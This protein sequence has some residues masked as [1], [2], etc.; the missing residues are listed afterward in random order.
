MKTTAV[1]YCDNQ[2]GKI[3][4]KVA[5]G[6]VRHSEKHEIVGI[7]DSSKVGL[8]AG[9]YLDGIKNGIPIFHDL[10]AAIESLTELPVCFIYGVAPL[11]AFLN[12][13]QRKI[14][15]R[16]I[17]KGMDIV[18]G[19]H[20][21]LTE[22]EEFIQ[23]AKKYGVAINDIRKPPAKKDLHLFS[24]R[25]L[26]IKIPIV[27]VLG[28]DGAVGK[29][30]T[31]IRLVK[32]L[33]KVGLNVAFVSTGQTGLIQGSKYGIAIDAIVEEFMTG[34]M[35]NAVVEAYENEH[36]DIII[37][38]GQGALSHPAYL[39][40][41]AIIRGARPNAI[42]VQH[43][44]KRKTICDFPYMAMPTLESEIELLEVFSKVKV[45]AL[46]INHEDMTDTELEETIENY[47]LQFR[48]PTTDALKYGCEKLVKRIIEVFPELKAKLPAKLIGSE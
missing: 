35:E 28:T 16:A 17:E 7:I 9:E 24:G 43:P 22:D 30:T 27:T 14:L 5:N 3:D 44:P 45:I 29:R 37:V 6:L 40:S 26:K 38:E 13:E 8:D 41:C 33:E 39:S 32:A 34:E 25:I 21:F 12:N 19:L 46:T 15:L 47:E 42:I 31:S 4:G 20:E 48:L 36:P 1:V 23:K 11:E 18:N 10:D 2:F